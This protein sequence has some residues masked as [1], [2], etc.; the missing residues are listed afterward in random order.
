M[1]K[2]LSCVVALL[3]TGFMFA[4]QIG[5]LNPYA[6]AVVPSLTDNTVEIS[7]KLNAPADSSYVVIYRDDIEVGVQALAANTAGEHNAVINRSQLT[8]PG[9]YT[10]AL[11]VYGTSN[12]EPVQLKDASGTAVSYSLYHPKGVAI[13]KNPMSPNFGRIL[14]AEAMLHAKTSGYISCPDKNGIY[15]FDAAFAQILNGSNSAFKGGLTY[16]A[17]L[18]NGTTTAYA[19]YRMRIS[20]KGRI[21]VS[22]QDDHLGL[23]YEAS[24]DLQTLTPIIASDSINGLPVVNGSLDLKED[25]DGNI[26]L[27]A[28]N[29]NSRGVAFNNN[30]WALSEYKIAPNGEVTSRVVMD[31]LAIKTMMNGADAEGNTWS[32]TL[33][34]SNTQIQYAADGGYWYINSRSAVTESGFGH[35]K[36]NGERDLIMSKVDASATQNSFYGGAGMLE[37]DGKLYVGMNPSGSMGVFAVDYSGDSVAVTFQKTISAAKIG[38]NMNDFSVDYAHNMYV[39]GNSGEKIIAFALPYSGVVETPVDQKVLVNPNFDHL[40]AIGQLVPEGW[41]PTKGVELTK[42]ADNVF[43][44]VF[45]TTLDTTGFAFTT[46]LAENNDGGGWAYLNAN[47]FSAAEDG[48]VVT[49]GDAMP[50]VKVGNTALRIAPAGQYKMTVNLNNM[51]LLVENYVEPTPALPIYIAF[52]DSLE[53][54]N[55][56]PS[57]RETTIAGMVKEGAEYISS[58][59]IINPSNVYRARNGYGLKLGTGSKTGGFTLT[60]A[61]T[62]NPDSII[63]RA[64][65]YSASEGAAVILGDSVNLVP[66]GNKMI[67]PI[68]KVY[69]GQTPVTELTIKTS[70]KRMYVVDVTIYPHGAVAPAPAPDRTFG[71]GEAIYLNV[72]SV[73]QKHVNY[74]LN[75]NAKQRAYFVNANGDSVMV[76]GTAI[77]HNQKVKYIAPAGDFRYVGFSR[78]KPDNDSIW[79]YTALFDLRGTTE[80]CVMKWNRAS[81]GNGYNTV[82]WGNYEEP[83]VYKIKHPWDLNNIDPWMWKTCEEQTDGT[84]T[85]TDIYWGGGCNIDP[86]VLDQNWIGAPTLVGNPYNGDSC[87]FVINPAATELS[88]ILTI[89]KLGEPNV[90]H[91]YELG[92]N[93]GWDPTAGIEMTALSDSIFEGTFTFTADTTWFAFTTVKP[94]TA[95]WNLVNAHRFGGAINKQLV[96]MGTYNMATGDCN[97]KALPGAYTFTVDLTNMTL[98][99][100]TSSTEGIEN[101]KAEE[102]VKKIYENGHIYIIRDGV[103]YTTAG[104]RVE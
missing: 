12:T 90:L 22:M 41:N 16:N 44:G 39:V 93:Q 17:K 47:R 89:T 63:V 73:E 55:T 42:K 1:K 58:V 64:A 13:D 84:W 36:A 104:A 9:N 53:L 7:Y 66:Y 43:E 86:K 102:Q 38:R 29:C 31:S 69:D 56:D 79:N 78:L 40:Y 81:T 96:T 92:D 3:V 32:T 70:A 34:P 33:T 95:D 61:E 103:R 82:V 101:M 48:A 54:Y 45:T 67:T 76:E 11:R 10:F 57:A 74:W 35:I 62:V 91:L 49:V 23:I 75:A 98:T 72:D 100:Q 59:A 97:F 46:V 5:Q 50:L 99:V 26:Y 52:R 77:D 30:G 51:T 60:L 68:K 85:L 8:E 80:N 21:F 71:L 2:I 15:A 83:V 4:E 14:S 28:L 20:R 25:E 65:A 18:L 94:A 6:Y 19:P 37:V 24:A 88:G 27:L 87:L